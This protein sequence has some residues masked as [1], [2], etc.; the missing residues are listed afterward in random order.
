[1]LLLGLANS[2][3]IGHNFPLIS[4]KATQ[5]PFSYHLQIPNTKSNN[6]GYSGG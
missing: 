2:Q 5:F 1:M 3:C 6:I 4:S